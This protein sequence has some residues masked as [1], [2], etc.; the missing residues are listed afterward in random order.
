MSFI[1][2]YMTSIPNS[3]ILQVINTMYM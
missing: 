3:R 2:R 1:L